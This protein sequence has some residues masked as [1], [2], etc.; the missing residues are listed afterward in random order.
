MTATPAAAVTPSN[1]SRRVGRC[2]GCKHCMW[3][4]PG[5][6]LWRGDP[7]PQMHCRVLGRLGVVPRK[8]GDYEHTLVPLECPK[9]G[10][11]TG[12]RHTPVKAGGY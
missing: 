3:I 5:G 10:P 6:Q 7:A 2:D 12:R 9:H 8:N 1:D 11:S 4:A